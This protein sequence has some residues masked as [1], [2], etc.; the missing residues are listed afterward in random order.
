M[1]TWQS[2]HPV[3][4]DAHPLCCR[5][6]Y[7]KADVNESPNDRNDRAIRVA[8]AWYMKRVPGMPIVVL[9]NDA[10]N[11][12]KA[13]EMG[14]NAM[15]VQVCKPHHRHVQGPPRVRH[16]ACQRRAA[17]AGGLGCGHQHRRYPMSFKA[18]SSLVILTRANVAR[19]QRSL[20]GFQDS[21]PVCSKPEVKNVHAMPWLWADCNACAACMQ[22]Y[23]KS[24]PD[25]PELADITAV[26]LNG[27]A[28]MD[29]DGAGAAARGKKR[30]RLY[31]DHRPM[32]SIAAGIK[33]GA[34]HQVRPPGDGAASMMATA[35]LR[36]RSAPALA[37][38]HLSLADRH[39]TT[40][41]CVLTPITC[42]RNNLR[43]SFR[44]T[45]CRTA[46]LQGGLC[47]HH[48]VLLPTGVSAG[49]PLQPL[50]GLRG[51]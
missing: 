15:S 31:E 35:M 37:H 36:M 49:E 14:I 20:G 6:T 18:H 45:H 3:D 42:H 19:T 32:S 46:W 16:M 8:A 26:D 10:E 5:E 33:Q 43:Y 29:A 48:E 21:A 1:S 24:L 2:E 23:A 17:S 30:K 28:D 47:M 38:L 12:R 41:V 22:A 4:L 9:T 44:V 51:F 27:Q 34:L 11:R 7:I 39:L 40:C 25:A 50:R 13:L